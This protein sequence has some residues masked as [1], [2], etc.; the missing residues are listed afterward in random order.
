MTRR[1]L[2]ELIGTA[3][4][5]YV[6]CG[7]ATQMFGF[8]SSGFSEASGVIATALAFG[9]VLMGLAYAIGPI[10]GAHVNPAVTL[11]ML[12]ARRIDP[13]RALGYWCAQFVGG[14]LGALALWGTLRGSPTYSK[15]STGLGANGFGS[16]SMIRI[17]WAG[18]FIIE[19]V[20]TTIFVYVILAVT[21]K[22][23]MTAT[24]GLVIGL[25]LTLV[26]LVGIGVDGTSVN[27][28]RS[29]GPA[30]IL[31][32]LAMHQVWLFLV[33]PLIGGALAAV[34]HHAMDPETAAPSVPASTPRPVDGGELAQAH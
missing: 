4:L 24:S 15:Q 6:G 10:S 26:H 28:A 3:V 2:A 30:V 9:L 22:R 27:P 12:I 25:T 5:V 29:L 31:G 17:D 11:G 7:T 13:M 32:G 20:L 19:I 33:A 1:L 21:S 34:L 23:G 14:I 18:A 16:A 8:P